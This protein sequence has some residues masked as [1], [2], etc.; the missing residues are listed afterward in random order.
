MNKVQTNWFDNA[1]LYVLMLMIIVFGFL[2]AEPGSLMAAFTAAVF[3]FWIVGVYR[4]AS[5]RQ[6]RLECVHALL[7]QSNYEIAPSVLDELA[8]DMAKPFWAIL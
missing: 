3:L 8:R 4:F 7:S 6:S 5:R 2:F 1:P